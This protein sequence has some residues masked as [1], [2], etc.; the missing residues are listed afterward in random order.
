M[1]S[2][3]PL[4]RNAQHIPR[5]VALVGIGFD[6]TLSAVAMSQGSKLDSEMVVSACR[7]EEVEALIARCTGDG[8]LEQLSEI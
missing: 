8:G 1:G 4:C 3:V 2:G 7:G 5:G 6:G